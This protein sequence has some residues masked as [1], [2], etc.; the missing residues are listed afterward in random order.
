MTCLCKEIIIIII[1]DGKYQ[2]VSINFCEFSIVNK[3]L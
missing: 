2:V 1:F 3:V